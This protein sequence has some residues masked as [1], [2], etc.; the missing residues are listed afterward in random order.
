MSVAGATG[1]NAS[2]RSVSS[3]SDCRATRRRPRTS[4]SEKKMDSA[5]MSLASPAKVD[6]GNITGLP[7]RVTG[8]MMD[9]SN[10]RSELHSDIVSVMARLQVQQ[11]LKL[12]NP[13][14]GQY[15]K[16]RI[17]MAGR[18]REGLAGRR[19]SQPATPRHGGSGRIRRM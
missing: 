19:E 10:S 15:A 11:A 9:D 4:S 1:P 14:R 16:R 2:S 7:V 13:R 17:D 8:S 5:G 12:S 6:Q 18:Q 3:V